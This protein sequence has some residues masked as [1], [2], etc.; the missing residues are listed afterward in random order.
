MIHAIQQTSNWLKF[1]TKLPDRKAWELDGLYI[2]K[3]SFRK[4][5]NFLYLP[6]IT[7]YPSAE[8]ITKLKALAKTENCFFIHLEPY[9]E[10]SKQIPI[11]Y[12]SPLK[13]IEPFTRV[14]DLTSSEDDI[15]QQFASQGRYLIRQAQKQNLKV[16]EEK[17]IDNF[18]N[19][20]IE[21]TNRNQF[22]ANSREY[23]A[24]LLNEIS[25][26]NLKIWTV[27]LN[28]QPVASIIVTFANNTATYYYGASS[29]R[30]E[31]RKLASTYFLQWHAIKHAKNQGYKY[32]DLMGVAPPHVKTHR[33]TGVS[34]FKSKFGGKI[35]EFT[36]ATDIILHPIRYLCFYLYKKLFR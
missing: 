26:D 6:A 3:L 11:G 16:I 5:W 17:S 13:Y 32:Y 12:K 10:K 23:Y 24:T 31:H 33:L 18:Y 15:F 9:I 28:N 36:P 1:Q 35:I 21:T 27:V 7:N 14:I 22:H 30:P 20:L 4:N 8:T 34:Q 29:S 19:L 25:A 2:Y